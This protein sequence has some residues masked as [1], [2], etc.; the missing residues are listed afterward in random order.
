MPPNNLEKLTR[1]RTFEGEDIVVLRPGI[2]LTMYSDAEF[3]TVMTAAADVLQAYLDFVPTG[4]IVASYVPPSGEYAPDSFVPFTLPIRRNLLNQLRTG[5]PSA[6]DEGYGFELTSTS[7]GQAGDY[8]VSLG[9]I[10]F[11]VS[12]EGDA[13]NETSLLRLELPWNLLNN[14]DVSAL[15]DFFQ[16]ASRLF[17][18]CSGNAGMSFNYT[19]GYTTAARDE[20][21]RLLPRFLGFDPAY[22][23]AQLEMRGKSPPAH[24]LNLLD[25]NLVAAL[26]GEERLRFE[27]SECEVGS[28]DG[29]LLIRAAKYP[30]VIDVNRQGHDIGLLPV[31]ARVLR[32]IRFNEAAFTGLSDMEYGQAWLERFDSLAPRDW[33][34]G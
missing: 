21:Q 14:L 29:G 12:E 18:F 2:A 8:G 32:P 34:N 16:Q 15:V 25:S 26:G 11:A 5:P 23:T 27:L 28:I 24:W 6:D 20:M 3:A 7:D 17:P 10:N 13:S 33:D 22:S 19:V 9:A 30:P 1:V 4:A 31:V